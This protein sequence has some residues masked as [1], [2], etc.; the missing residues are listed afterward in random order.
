M[1]WITNGRLAALL[2]HVLTSPAS[3]E[4]DDQYG[5]EQ[6]CTDLATLL[7]KYCGGQIASTTQYAPAPGNMDWST[8]YRLAIELNRSSPPGGG[9]WRDFDLPVAANPAS[10][11]ATHARVEHPGWPRC[12]WQLEVANGDTELGYQDWVQHQMEA[13]H[14]EQ[15]KSGRDIFV[16][17]M[18]AKFVSTSV[19]NLEKPRLRLDIAAQ[20]LLQRL[21]DDTL[22]SRELYD[23]NAE[24]RACLSAL[25]SAFEFPDWEGRTVGAFLK[26]FGVSLDQP[27]VNVLQ[28]NQAQMN[29]DGVRAN[30]VTLEEFWNARPM[31]SGWLLPSGLEV[32]F[33]AQCPVA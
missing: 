20:E 32:W 11:S 16:E 8:H 19:S 3:G 30:N 24:L 5:F 10:A 31:G 28:H 1:K 7:C 6:F 14:N 25:N 4:I 18:Q 33:H 12:D 15:A 22:I 17:A 27:G 9:V 2:S 26:R 29:K 21:P 13:P 23:S